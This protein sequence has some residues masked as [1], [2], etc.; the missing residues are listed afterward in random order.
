MITNPKGCK[1]FRERINKQYFDPSIWNAFSKHQ[2]NFGELTRKEM[3]EIAM[4]SAQG[5]ALMHAKDLQYLVLR[6]Q[7]LNNSRLCKMNLINSE[8][9]KFVQ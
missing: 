2:A 3:E 5:N 1:A 6:N 8:T 4:N 9:A 7:F